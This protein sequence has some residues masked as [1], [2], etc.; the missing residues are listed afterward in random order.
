MPFDTSAPLWPTPIAVVSSQ[1]V[2]AVFRRH[3]QQRRA[4]AMTPVSKP[5]DPNGT[6]EFGGVGNA[7]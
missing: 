4:V 6:K 5:V 3:E 2:A 1:L 7:G